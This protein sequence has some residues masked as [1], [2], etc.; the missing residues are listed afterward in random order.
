MENTFRAQVEQLCA[1]DKKFGLIT[2]EEYFNLVEELKVAASRDKSK[3]RRQYYILQRYEVLQCGDVEKLIKKR[4]EANGEE[5]TVYYAHID[6]LYDIVKRAHTSTGHGGRD[7]NK[8]MKTLSSK[9]PNIT[10][11][12]CL[13][14]LV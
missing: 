6:E 12:V 9:Y 1:S 8:M 4:N 2:Q 7:K 14:I 13:I 5:Q 3:T 10:R 11:E